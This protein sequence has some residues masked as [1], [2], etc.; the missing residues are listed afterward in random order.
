MRELRPYQKDILEYMNSV[1]SPVLWVEMRLGKTLCVIRYA[2]QPNV[3][4]KHILVVA[5]SSALGSWQRELDVENESWTRVLGNRKKKVKTLTDQFSSD[6]TRWTLVN[7]EI[8]RS[9]GIIGQLPWDL[10]VLDESASCIRYPDTQITKYFLTN[11]NNTKKRIV[12]AGRPDPQNRLLD[13]WPQIAFANNGS[14]MGCTNFWQWRQRYFYEIGYD[15]RPKRGVAVKIK[16]EISRRACVLRREHVNLD[17]PKIYQN[18]HFNLS[19][20]ARRLYKEADE[21]FQITLTPAGPYSTGE[22]KVTQWQIVKYGWLRQIAGGMFDKK[23]IDKSKLNGLKDLLEGELSEESVVVW[24]CYN[25]ELHAAK[26]MLGK[27]VVWVEGS[28]S[29]E[30]RERRFESFRQGKKRILL[31]QIK[32]AETGIELGKANT[33]IYYSLP[34]SS[35]AWSQSQDRILGDL[36][37][38]GVLILSL[39][40]EG[41]ID[42]AVYEALQSKDQHGIAFLD[43]VFEIL[44]KKRRE[45]IEGVELNGISTCINNRPR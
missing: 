1:Y 13:Y 3:K 33:A 4:F 23:V 10:V 32:I 12:M 39:I 19:G 15:W 17:V 8:H 16:N 31:C 43:K 25:N 37:K 34:T 5:P 41:T 35:L 21:E 7:K 40:S 14:W 30:E 29:M 28:I 26:D 18:R 44:R 24:F 9:C 2:N 22:V 27:E 36:T 11:F 6:S 42:E 38:K 45:L 20:Q